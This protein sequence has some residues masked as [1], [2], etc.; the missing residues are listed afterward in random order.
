MTIKYSGRK[1]GFTL[2]ELLVVIVII[3]FLATAI[4]ASLGDARVKARDVRR[5]ADLDSLRSAIELYN[6]A[7]SQY[8]GSSDTTT[9]DWTPAFK[10][11]LASYLSLPPKDPLQN[12]GSRYYGFYKIGSAPDPSCDNTYTLLMYLEATSDQDYGKYTCGYGTNHYFK[13]LGK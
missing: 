7:N 8:P 2:M 4:S 12:N 3:G 11:Q 13:L 5:K 1:G 9:G 6:D 10:T